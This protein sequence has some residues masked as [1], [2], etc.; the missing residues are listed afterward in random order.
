MSPSKWSQ[1]N[2][3]QSSGDLDHETYL[4]HPGSYERRLQG[5]G[6][7]SNC[8]SKLELPTKEWTWQGNNGAALRAGIAAIREAAGVGEAWVAHKEEFI[9]VVKSV[10]GETVV[11]E[12]GPPDDVDQWAVSLSAS[13]FDHPA[14]EN[15]SIRCTV[16]TYG[17]STLVTTEV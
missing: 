11:A 12:I 7:L 5:L 13:T 1:S 6:T 15:Q 8:L 3:W 16:T 2:N 14:R 17:P 10:E 4:L 9:G